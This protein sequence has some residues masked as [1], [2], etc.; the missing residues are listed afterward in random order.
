M[1][2]KKLENLCFSL[3]GY[4]KQN[5]F[6]GGLSGSLTLDEKHKD[7]KLSIM[8]FGQGEWRLVL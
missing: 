2:N 1:D 6:L 7:W 5:W 4:M 8:G 3:L